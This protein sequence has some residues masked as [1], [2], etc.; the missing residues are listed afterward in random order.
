MSAQIINDEKSVS[1]AAGESSGVAKAKSSFKIP[2]FKNLKSAALQQLSNTFSRNQNDSNVPV[3]G[4]AGNDDMVK[5]NSSF[6]KLSSSGVSSH[7]NLFSKSQ[8][9]TQSG[10]YQPV[11]THIISASEFLVF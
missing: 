8:L 10:L 5:V 3:T 9:S 6:K 1:E 4:A 7:L 11:A 2:G